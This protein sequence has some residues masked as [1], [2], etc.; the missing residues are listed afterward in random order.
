M[1]DCLRLEWSPAIAETII[2][3]YDCV[4]DFGP[5]A[6]PAPPVPSPDPP[7]NISMNV[8][9]SHINLFLIVSEDVCLMARID[10]VTLEKTVVKSWAHVGG[11]KVLDT[12]PYRGECRLLFVLNKNS[13]FFTNTD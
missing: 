9:L 13:I 1:M 4:H 11:M 10:A 3:L 2:S 6:P 7:C 8:A 5:P 12:I